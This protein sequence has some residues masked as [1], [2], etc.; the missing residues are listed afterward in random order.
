[1]PA[2]RG[3]VAIACVL[4][5]LSTPLSSGTPWTQVRRVPEG[6]GST[7]DPGPDWKDLALRV[8][9]PGEGGVGGI[10]LLGGQAYVPYADAP[11]SGTGG[12]VRVDLDTGRREVVVEGPAF[13]TLASDGAR[14]YGAGTS[15]VAAY[16][17]PGGDP[18][19]NWSW[20]TPSIDPNQAWCHALTLE[21]SALT[22]TCNEYHYRSDTQ[23][24]TDW[25]AVV[26]RIDA[27]DGD[28]AWTWSWDAASTVERAGLADPD[29]PGTPA[30][31]GALMFGAAVLGPRVMVSVRET[32]S[33]TATDPQMSG[34][35]TASRPLLVSLDKQSGQLTWT[36][37]GDW[38]SSVFANV[39]GG[40]GYR[41]VEGV[42]VGAPTGTPNVVFAKLGTLEALSAGS[43]EE[44]WRKE[45]GRRD[46][47]PASFAY[48]GLAFDGEAVYAASGQTLYR[49]GA[50]G[51]GGWEANIPA[52][53]GERLEEDL[54]VTASAVHAGGWSRATDTGAVY[55][56]DKST[57]DMLWRF[58]VGDP[59]QIAVSGEA[60][61]FV[62]ITS[63]E[64]VVLGRTGASPE[65]VAGTSTD[66]PG[67]GEEVRVDL[68]GSGA[69]LEGPVTRYKAIWGDGTETGWRTDPVLAHAYNQSG[70]VTARF[71]VGND[72]NQTASTTQTFHVGQAEPNL[73]STAF[74][75]QNQD[76]TFGIIGIALALAGGLVGMARRRRRRNRLQQELDAVERLYEQTRDRPPECEAQLTERKA[77][78]RGLLADGD[79]TEEQ[80]QIVEER[81]RDLRREVRTALLDDRFAF[82][83]HGM[84][85]RLE[86]MLADARINA[87]EREHFLKALDAEGTLTDEQKE[88]VRNLIDDWFERDTGSS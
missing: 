84:V 7:P 67:V 52:G 49:Y 34:G 88:R 75:P 18:L 68:G 22:A 10:V 5:I 4:A 61:A 48:A 20:D 35:A 51:S 44:L 16:D 37:E 19:W 30:S 83:P 11:G 39:S 87:W 8:E 9:L 3:L 2:A 56:F 62:D 64:L 80:L 77:H 1:M 85:L 32:R 71:V 6:T 31:T 79:L 21:E 42:T 33:P 60:L 12:V 25:N 74:A 47:D 43:G 13:D 69:G 81:I 17:L 78:A 27:R 58:P 29:A 53:S 36:R 76:M 55:A 72:A 63:D 57:G 66:Y 24:Y 41:S 59:Q 14:L 54:V 65:P 86:D 28:V 15:T 40:T 70:D 82:L 45:I 73:I 46:Y 23:T 50:D 38:R 26:A